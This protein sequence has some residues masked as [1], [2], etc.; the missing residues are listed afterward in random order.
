MGIKHLLVMCHFVYLN[1]MAYKI[2]KSRLSY[3]LK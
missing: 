3:G 1:E 2:N